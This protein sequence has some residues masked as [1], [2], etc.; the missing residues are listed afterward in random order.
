MQSVQVKKAKN[1]YIVSCYGLDGDNQ[2]I[3]KSMDEV[4]KEVEK[5]LNKKEETKIT[6]V[7]ED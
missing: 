7:D 6:R 1:G 4:K 5:M 3:C 2:V